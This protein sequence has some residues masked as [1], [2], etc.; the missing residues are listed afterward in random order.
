M[1]LSNVG[2][3]QA[4]TRIYKEECCLTFDTP[5]SDGGLFVD[6]T[7]FLAFGREQ[8]M[9][10]FKKTGSSVYLHIKHTLKESDEEDDRPHKKPTLLAI[11]VEG[12]F[13][14]KEPEYDETLSIVILPDY[15]TLPLSSAE[16]PEKV[17]L[18]VDAVVQ[19]VG[20]ERKEQVSA[21]TADKKQLS[22]YAQSL[23]QL[24]NGVR[25]PPSGWKCQRCDKQENLWLNLTDGSILCG[26]RNFDGTGGNN[27]ALEHY[28]NVKYPLAVKLGTITADLET[29]D[30]FSY[31]EDD[32]VT[33]PLLA[34][35]LAHFGINF[36]ALKKTE[37]TTA[38]RE[39]DQNVNFDWNRIQEKGKELEPLFG[40]GFTGLVNLGNSCYLASVLQIIFATRDFQLR[41]YGNLKLDDAFQ[42]APADPTQDL[43]TQLSK[44]GHGLLSGKYS[45]QPEVQGTDKEVAN[46]FQ[47]GIP[48]RMFKSL[49]GAGHPEFASSRQQDAFEFFQYFLEQVERGN[50]ANPNED[51]SRCFKFLVEERIVCCSSGKV[52][53]TKRVD[54]A[55]SL[56][57]PLDAATNRDEVAAYEKI[58]SEGGNSG[59]KIEVV[60]P[61]IP[62]SACLDRFAAP[63]EVEFY[64]TAVNART[65]ALKMTSL[66]TFPTYL[67]LHMRKFQLDASWVPKKLDVFLD[68]PDTID[69]SHMRGK[70]LQPGEELLPEA[71]DEAEGPVADEAIVSQLMDM[72]FPRVRCE[73]A[74]I[75]TSNHG[76]EPAME[77]LL[78]H[79]DD[80]DIDVPYSHSSSNAN[81]DENAVQSL[82]ALG[83]SADLARKA[84]RATGGRTEDAAEWIFSNSDDANAMELDVGGSS[85]PSSSVPHD[86]PDGSGKYK[87]MGFVSHM[88]SSTL[89]GHY[90][91]HILKEGRWVIF[92]DGKVALSGDPPKDMG[93]LYVFQRV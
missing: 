49:I 2:M 86:L 92:N 57:L 44:L 69:I 79:M 30:V 67:L 89:C 27:H 26:R 88:G 51:P 18:C 70:G 40:P 9:W 65:T 77:W 1:A 66:A 61:R 91:A 11:G 52:K 23:Q 14:T 6:L 3:P 54:N 85:T 81:V 75:F 15:Q 53:Y 76:A 45:E 10:N 25:V 83:F 4:S 8:A 41:Y 36:A 48:P 59:E 73:K 22:I 64:S 12:G 37:M 82:V 90:V 56:T 93:Y 31:A 29:A 71:D 24:N 60:R 16:L 34:Q 42:L 87:L 78:S 39:L 62:L 63:D 74:A 5:K 35:H 28:A 43:N 50:V 80:P 21:W 55:L 46:Q 32:T 38:E 19:S 17:R 20:A 58:T 13:E 33:D 84:L 47:K 68:V 7:S 72:G